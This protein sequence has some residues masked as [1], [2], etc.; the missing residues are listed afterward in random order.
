MRRLQPR[1]AVDTI[2]EAVRTVLSLFPDAG[3]DD[4]SVYSEAYA[5][6]AELYEVE[7]F[8]GSLVAVRDASDVVTGAP[9]VFVWLAY[10]PTKKSVAFLRA[11]D[12]F[13]EARAREKGAREVLFCTADPGFEKVAP[14]FGW[15]PKFKM[16][17]KE[18]RDVNSDD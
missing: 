16:L 13:L 17:K 9:I 8:P 11:L 18:V 6:L 10:N 15:S 1:E 2:G 12:R 4:L 3:L 14:R 7:G 5:G